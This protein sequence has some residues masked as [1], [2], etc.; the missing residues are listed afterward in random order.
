MRCCLPVDSGEARAIAAAV[1]EWMREQN[2]AH[3]ANQRG[4]TK[5]E[6]QRLSQFLREQGEP[7]AAEDGITPEHKLRNS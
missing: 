2:E 1:R 6:H 7:I 4:L 3:L 5:E